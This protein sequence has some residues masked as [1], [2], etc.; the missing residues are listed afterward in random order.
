MGNGAEKAAEIENR[1]NIMSSLLTFMWFPP[2]APSISEIEVEKADVW[3]EPK[4]WIA[5]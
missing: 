4:F 2:A 5:I 1:K 3:I